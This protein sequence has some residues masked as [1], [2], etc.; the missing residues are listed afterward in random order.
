[1]H[2]C[3]CTGSN[4]G[5]R[6]FLLTMQRCQLVS[7]APARPVPF[8]L[9]AVRLTSVAPVRPIPFDH[10]AVRLT[11]VAPV[12]L[13]SV[14][15][16]RLHSTDPS[17]LSPPPGRWSSS[18]EAQSRSPSRTVSLTP[19]PPGRWSSFPEAQLRTYSLSSARSSL[20]PTRSSSALSDMSPT[21]I[22]GDHGPD[23]AAGPPR[24]PRAILRARAKVQHSVVQAKAPR[25]LS[26]PRGRLPSAFRRASRC[27]SVATSASD[28]H[29][30]R[31]VLLPP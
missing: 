4:E 14:E 17:R 23:H 28:S 2:C 16:V 8:D 9:D 11:S 30:A 3:I 26:V 10:D 19:P 24:Q 27:C 18:P 15:P 1:M 21:I 29:V 31:A 13:R 20:A 12:R 7:V 6:L 25:A 5:P 22:G